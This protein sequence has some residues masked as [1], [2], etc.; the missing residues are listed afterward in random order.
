[1]IVAKPARKVPANVWRVGESRIARGSPSRFQ[2]RFPVAAD[3][4]HQIA[5][6]YDA[7]IT[8]MPGYAA[9]TSYAIAP[10]GTILAAYNAMDP[11]GHVSRMLAAVKT[12]A[13]KAAHAN[14]G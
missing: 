8:L 3:S 6:T 12:W 4:T 10:D 14:Q 5:R 11:D 9:R 2:G 13:A 7:T 1:M